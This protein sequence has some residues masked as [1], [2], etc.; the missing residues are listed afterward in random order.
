MTDTHRQTRETNRA[1]SPIIGVVLLIGITIVLSAV[2]AVF[3]LEAIQDQHEQDA[4]PWDE[5][6]PEA[7]F[8]IDRIGDDAL[9]T[10]TGG[11]EIDATE[12][13]V[14][15]D[16]NSSAQFD[17]DTVTNGE[18][19]MKPVTADNATV[20]VVWSTAYSEETLAEAEI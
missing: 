5:Q 9:V 10:Y 16:L 17:G 3:A 20:R 1:V 6:P 13:A 19:V 18:T 11:E 7:T 14:A 12:I 8:D 4:Q 15:G 2:V